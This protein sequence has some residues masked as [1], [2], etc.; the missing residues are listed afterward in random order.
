MINLLFGILII[1]LLLFV[2]TFRLSMKVRLVIAMLFFLCTAVMFYIVI[3]NTNDTAMPGSKV[4]TQEMLNSNG[5][6]NL[7]NGF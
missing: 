3:Y 5:S 4:I 6:D 1:S 2:A 7:L